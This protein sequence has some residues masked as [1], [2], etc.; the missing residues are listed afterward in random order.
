[1]DVPR[2][3]VGDPADPAENNCACPSPVPAA[4]S[5]IP[6]DTDGFWRLAPDLYRAQLPNDYEVACATL[7][8]SHVLALNR[9]ARAIL[10]SFA[11]PQ[12][13]RPAMPVAGIAPEQAWQVARRL[14]QHQ[15]LAPT[16]APLAPPPP[17]DS[18]TLTA[19]IHVTN[20]C[21]L[22]C[23]YCYVAKNDEAMDE[24]TGR[25]AI[26]AV[27]RSA[28]QD[29]YRAIKLKYAGGEASLNF[30]LV[31]SLHEYAAER[32]QDT[33]LMLR[34]AVLSNGVA[35]TR[36]MLAFLHNT[37]MRLMI[38]LDGIGA[39]HDSQR[40]FANGRGSFTQVAR[41]IERALA[42]GVAP[43]LSITVTGNNAGQLKETVEFALERGLRFNLNFYRDNTCSPSDANLAAD[44]E[45][46]IAGVRAAFAA[47]AKN[48]PRHRLID[49]LV[50]RSTFNSRHTRA[51]GA[52][53]DYLVVDHR[54]QI[55]RCQ[56]ELERPVTTIAAPN[57]LHIIRLESVSFRNLSVDQKQGCRDC[58]WRYWCGGGCSFLTHRTTGQHD[59]RS[60]YCQVYQ[61]LYPDALYLEGLRLVTWAP[62]EGAA[63][64]VVERWV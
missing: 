15:L 8:G 49:G 33:G 36:A 24:T 47:I 7:T 27:V 16:D 3:F 64:E 50:D 56:M 38:S 12:P 35:L 19:W 52:G 5:S 63:R 4:V 17:R 44:D 23:H 51:C 54:G 42:A 28:T 46:V 57:P 31:R 62:R 55:A 22:R 32:A 53:H 10:D 21:N 29:G 59:V 60:P 41:S 9:P 13:L 39:A 20:A 40:V 11:T 25:Q 58:Q 30:Q 1:M 6:L 45:H 14:A 43:D 26:D 18:D 34:E 2:I 37:G 48:I 61:A